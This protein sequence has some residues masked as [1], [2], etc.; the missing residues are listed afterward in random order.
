MIFLT[1]TRPLLHTAA[2][3]VRAVLFLVL[4]AL[5]YL[6][7][8]VVHPQEEK[9]AFPHQPLLQSSPAVILDST[10]DLPAMIQAFPVPVLQASASSDLLL[11]A[12]ASSDVPF[13]GG[14]G[15]NLTLIY[16]YQGEIQI[17]VE[18]IYPARAL[19]LLSG[20]GWHMSPRN[21]RISGQDAV[22]MENSQSLRVHL[23]GTEALYAVTISRSAA[24]EMT[25]ILRSLQIPEKGS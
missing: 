1:R 25:D 15:R 10:D 19:S 14:F 5:L 6:V 12:G 7:V 9:Q 4:A 22:S 3:L 18:T 20:S 21:W 13:E 23:Q 8:I 16:L 2:L 24:G 11:Q 17:Q